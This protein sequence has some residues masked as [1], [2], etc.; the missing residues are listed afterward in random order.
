MVAALEKALQE[1]AVSTAAQPQQPRSGA[2]PH[3]ASAAKAPAGQC[4]VP[5]EGLPAASTAGRGRG[6][7]SGQ[8]HVQLHASTSARGRGQ[9]ETYAPLSS[10]AAYFPE[11]EPTTCATR[12]QPTP[13][14][15]GSQTLLY[16]PYNWPYKAAG[17]TLF[18]IPMHRGVQKYMFGFNRC[19]AASVEN[20]FMVT[21]GSEGWGSDSH[22]PAWIQAFIKAECTA[23][24][25]P[26]AQ[27]AY[28][29]MLEWYKVT[30][31]NYQKGRTGPYFDEFL[32]VYHAADYVKVD[33]R[34]IT[35]VIGETSNLKLDTKAACSKSAKKQV[36]AASAVEVKPTTVQKAGPSSTTAGTSTT[37]AGPSTATAGPSAESD[38]KAKA[39]VTSTLR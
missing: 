1:S 17:T 12:T 22:F 28:D 30:Q 7:G 21:I 2:Q 35:K 13:A 29:Y 16:A 19:R 20:Y 25:P 8:G 23:P 34:R 27:A 37:S 11:S 39:E 18:L 31:W 3:K 5:G 32:S 4:P 10:L 6:Q 36:A 33:D 26:K 24:P 38:A 14:S 9:G 15:E